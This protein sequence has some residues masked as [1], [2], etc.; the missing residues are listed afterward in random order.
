LPSFRDRVDKCRDPAKNLLETF[1]AQQL[2]E[3]LFSD[4]IA[5][6]KFH[7]GRNVLMNDRVVNPAIEV[8]PLNI[9][10]SERIGEFRYRLLAFFR[11]DQLKDVRPN[12]SPI[13]LRL[14][15]VLREF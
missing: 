2:L 5:R 1:P 6:N 11:P 14:N 13:A 10:P 4:G 9:A 15:L 8:D 7:A 12:N 3:L